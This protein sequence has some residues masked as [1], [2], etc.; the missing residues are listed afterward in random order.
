MILINA[1]SPSL[2]DHSEGLLTCNVGANMTAVT[3]RLFSRAPWLILTALAGA[4]AVAYMRLARFAE[5]T[6]AAVGLARE[7]RLGDAVYFFL[8]GYIEA[9][10]GNREAAK[11]AD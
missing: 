7:T 4:W 8:Y 3:E 10:R 2:R 9:D 1:S 6:L 11:R 5:V